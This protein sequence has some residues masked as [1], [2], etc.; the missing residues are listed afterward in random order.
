MLNE[1]S[2]VAPFH[3]KNGSEMFSLLLVCEMHVIKG[4]IWQAFAMI[5]NMKCSDPLGLV[6]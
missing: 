3:P 5:N 2:A 6:Q 1:S 4:Y